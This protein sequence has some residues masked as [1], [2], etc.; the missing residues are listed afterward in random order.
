MLTHPAADVFPMMGE[1]E[2]AELTKDIEAHGQRVPIVTYRGEILDGRSR[3]QACAALGKLPRTVEWDGV[4]S[5]TEFAWSMNGSRRHLTPSQ[6]AAVAVEMLPL[7]EAEAKE[8]QRLGKAIVPYPDAAG[9]ARDHAAEITGASPR[10]VSE[11]KRLKADQPDLYEQVKRGESTVPEAKRQ[12]QRRQAEQE[13]A[14]VQMVLDAAPDDGGRLA[15]ASLKASYSRCKLKV[16]ELRQLDPEDIV[17]VLR[18][19]EEDS[20]RWFIR[21]TRAWLDRFEAALGRG[22]HLVGGDTSHG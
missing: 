20:A 16:H 8:R 14:D 3:F 1:S 15:R 10:Y 9:P 7:L 5:P 17:G 2:L 12:A 22:L 4:G 11:T 13:A 18:D 6:K 21:D 19:G